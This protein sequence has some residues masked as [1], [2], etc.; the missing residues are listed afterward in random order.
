MAKPVLR[1]AKH[2]EQCLQE[3]RDALN[4]NRLSGLTLIFGREFFLELRKADQWKIWRRKSE[5]FG[6]KS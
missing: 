2:L 4:N 3:L 1:D 6:D 5:L